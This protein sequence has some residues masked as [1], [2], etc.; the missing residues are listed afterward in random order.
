ML[1]DDEKFIFFIKSQKEH[2]KKLTEISKGDH[3]PD[4]VMESDFKMYDLDKIC[5][6]CTAFT[7]KYGPS[8]T[9]DALYYQNTSEGLELYF[10]EF[11]GDKL[12]NKPLTQIFKKF[13]FKY[14]QS[15]NFEL[16]STFKEEI[17]NINPNKLE[18]FLLTEINKFVIDDDELKDNLEEK[19]RNLKKSELKNMLLTE[20]ESSLDKLPNQ[21]YH[22]NNFLIDEPYYIV[23]N[24]LL[25]VFNEYFSSFEK[26]FENFYKDI[27]ILINKCLDG[28][29]AVF[30]HFQFVNIKKIYDKYADDLLMGLRMKPI[31]SLFVSLPII[32]EEFFNNHPEYKD[33]Y[34]IENFY[35]FIYNCKKYLWVIPVSCAAST[36]L[37]SNNQEL[38]S[39]SS[40]FNG[41]YST[42]YLSIDLLLEDK[43]EEMEIDPDTYEGKLHIAY[44]NYVKAGMFN[45]YKIREPHI[46]N[47]YINKNFIEENPNY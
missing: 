45:E 17:L 46:F 27:S 1:T 23:K 9:T 12:D 44:R 13:L 15:R 4:P 18:I 41:R 19:I 32:Y 38:V 20:I 36:L 33:E 16:L 11:K 42:R 31:E 14:K 29:W 21:E 28:N 10:I 39:Q 47:L 26:Y 25:K 5:K 34:Y 2:Y 8:K 3:H 43:N 35:D 30:K 37:E 7:Q 24:T 6:N 22:I 40:D